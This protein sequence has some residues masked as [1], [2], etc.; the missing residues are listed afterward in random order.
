MSEWPAIEAEGTRTE[1]DQTKKG[2]DLKAKASLEGLPAIEAGLAAT[3]ETERQGEQRVKVTGVERHHVQFGQVANYLTKLI[4]ALPAKRLWILL[5]EWVAVPAELQPLL[6]DLLRRAVMPVPGVTLKIAAIEQR[7]NFRV[8][9]DNDYLGFELGADIQADLDLDDFMVFE[10]DAEKAKEFFRNLLFR[11]I[12]TLIAEEPNLGPAPSSAADLQKMA[13]TQRNAIDDF[14]RAAEGV[15]R[16]AINILRLA[17]QRADDNPIAV[18]HV[19][20]AARRWYLQNKEKE[21]PEDAKALLHWVID[22]VIGKRQARAFLLHQG[23]GRNALIS[24][25]YDARVLHVIRRGVAAQDRAGVRFDVYAIDYGCYVDLINT[26]KAPQGLYEVGDDEQGEWVEVPHGDY[27][28]I[29]RAILELEQFEARPLRTSCLTGRASRSMTLTIAEIDVEYLAAL[30]DAE[31]DS[32]RARLY[33]QTEMGKEHVGAVWHVPGDELVLDRLFL[34]RVQL[35]D[36][37]LPEH[38]ELHRIVVP[39]APDD[40]ITLA[41]LLRHELEHARQ[42]DAL[43]RPI[44]RLQRWIEDAVLPYKAA[45][46]NNCGGGLINAVPTEVD[47]NA[48]AS[49]YIAGRFSADERAAFREGDRRPLACS[50]LPPEPFDTLPARMIAFAFVHRSAVL[51]LASHQ[52]TAGR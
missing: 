14:V 41:A 50:L 33:L 51:A 31:I 26:A 17:A 45:E 28:S 19:R 23:E 36:A 3:K 25:L 10:N 44:L 8:N 29:R 39:A 11:H 35:A 49:V 52:Q 30:A 47:C 4:A 27:R 32:A 24:A 34:D 18:E 37:N 12:S 6:A 2:G 13:F 1:R 42:F 48:A 16:D 40:A 7:S 22:E 21:I 5:D 20:V 15:P 43:G 9:R 46:L 38:R